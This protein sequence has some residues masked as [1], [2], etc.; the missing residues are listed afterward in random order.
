MYQFF[1]N[2]DDASVGELLL[3][4]TLLDKGAVDAIVADHAQNPS[5]RLAQKKLAEEVTTLVHGEEALQKAIAETDVRFKRDLSAEEKTALVKKV[6]SG[7]AL[8]EAL[9]MCGYA[10]S[11]SA[12]RRLV[13]GRAVKINGVLVEDVDKVLDAKDLDSDGTMVLTAGKSQPSSVLGIQ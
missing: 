12:A 6:P 5:A 11:K 2:V 13:E 9:M 4:L 3:K 1:L 7:T 8:I 10:D